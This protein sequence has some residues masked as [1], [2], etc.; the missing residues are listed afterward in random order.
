MPYL[1]IFQILTAKWAA[2]EA[3]ETSVQQTRL[4]LYERKP[5]ASWIAEQEKPTVE[6]F[7]LPYWNDSFWGISS[8][9]SKNQ[10]T[11]PPAHDVPYWMDPIW[12][13]DSPLKKVGLN[14]DKMCYSLDIDKTNIQAD[15]DRHP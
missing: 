1:A 11:T 13:H 9:S 5:R 12:M 3:V 4:P 14:R 8:S 2:P 7:N 6:S 10:S 15:R